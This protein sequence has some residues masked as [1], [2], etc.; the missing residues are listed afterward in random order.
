MFSYP[1][2]DIRLQKAMTKD[3]E[4]NVRVW[5]ISGLHVELE[6]IDENAIGINTLVTKVEN[7]GVWVLLQWNRKTEP[8]HFTIAGRRFVSE[9]DKGF[10]KCTRVVA[11][12]STVEELKNKF[13]NLFELD[14]TLHVFS[15]NL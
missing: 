4:Q 10:E 15:A 11:K 8:K 14:G 6:D 3:I 13:P 7:I 9:L 5:F 12:L 2:K 1:D